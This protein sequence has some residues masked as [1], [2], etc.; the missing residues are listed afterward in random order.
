[1][2]VQSYNSRADIKWIKDTHLKDIDKKYKDGLKFGSFVIYGNEDCPS[3]IELYEDFDPHYKT[4]PFMIL[5]YDGEK[6][7]EVK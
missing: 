3:A 1:M 4:S 7:V 6:Y 2:Q 5:K